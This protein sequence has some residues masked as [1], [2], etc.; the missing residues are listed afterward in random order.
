MVENKQNKKGRRR[1]WEFVV[2]KMNKWINKKKNKVNRI[3]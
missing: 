3:K 2:Q 1:S